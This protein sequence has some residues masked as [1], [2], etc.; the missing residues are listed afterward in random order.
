MVKVYLIGSLSNRSIIDLGNKIRTLGFDVFEDWLGP[1]ESADEK[2]NEYRQRRGLNYRDALKSY[3]AQHIFE[4]DR[5]HLV[6]S[7]IV[8]LVMPAGKSG[9]LELGFCAG[10]SYVL[11]LYDSLS[12]DTIKEKQTYILMDGEPERVDIMHSFADEIFMNEQEL[13]SQLEHSTLTGDL[14]QRPDTCAVSVDINEPRI[15]SREE[16]TG[17]SFVDAIGQKRSPYTIREE[18][19]S[20]FSDMRHGKSYPYTEASDRCQ[21][22]RRVGE[23]QANQEPSISRSRG[24][25]P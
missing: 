14:R 4:F 20:F 16:R 11:R 6:D 1:G 22:Q 15:V 21:C 19:P 8:V 23:I 5:K 12:S 10:I 24:L 17:G 7:D 3:A 25:A 2:F 9:H 13:I 18:Y